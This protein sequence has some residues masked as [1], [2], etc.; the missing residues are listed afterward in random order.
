MDGN[1]GPDDKLRSVLAMGG[2]AVDRLLVAV[3][4]VVALRDT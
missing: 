4:N 2:R 1:E 3:N